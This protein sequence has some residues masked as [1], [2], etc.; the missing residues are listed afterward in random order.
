M[1]KVS[2]EQVQESLVRLNIEKNQQNKI[3]A[4][5]QEILKQE[6]LHKDPVVKNKNEFGIVL[7]APELLGKEY[8]ATVYQIREGEDHG[9]VLKR[10]STAAHNQN[11]AAKKKN[12]LLKSIGDACQNFKRKFIKEQCVN[13]KTKNPVR[14]LISNNALL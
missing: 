2:I 13:I 11:A 5:L 8:T 10:I 14:V 1:T 4:E 12:N 7:Y 6:K 9:T 3:V